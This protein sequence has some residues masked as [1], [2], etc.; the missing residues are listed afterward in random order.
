[1]SCYLSVLKIPVSESM[2]AFGCSHPALYP[3]PLQLI[4]FPPRFSPLY[5]P[6]ISALCPI[7]DLLVSS[8]ICSLVC[9][10]Q[11]T[12]SFL[13]A[14]FILLVMFSLLLSSPCSGSFQMVWAVLSPSHLQ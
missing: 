13:T 5:N 6:S 3:N 14:Q 9:P 7:G 12:A 1:M 8:L 2:L 11:H 4:N 10:F